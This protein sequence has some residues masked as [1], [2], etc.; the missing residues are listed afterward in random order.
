MLVPENVVDWKILVRGGHFEMCYKISKSLVVNGNDDLVEVDDGDVSEAVH[1]SVD[2][3][4]DN[5]YTVQHI[6]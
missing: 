3:I 5:G 1:V 4:V 2:T 6:L